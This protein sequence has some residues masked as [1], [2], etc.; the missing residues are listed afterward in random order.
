MKQTEFMPD[1]VENNYKLFY[2]KNIKFKPFFATL[3]HGILPHDKPVQK[4]KK[5]E[6]E[7]ISD[8]ENLWDIANEF[9]KDTN[10]RIVS[11]EEKAFKLITYISAISVLLV[12]FL[13]VG[14][15]G[16]FRWSV[17]IALFFLIIA[18]LISLRCIGLK[19]KMAIHV[20][21]MLNFDDDP[22]SFPT[23]KTK[24]EIVA[25]LINDS[26]YNHNVAD[27]T[28]DV[29]K[30]SR[31]MLTIG[32][33]ITLFSGI[34][35]INHLNTDV[36]MVPQQMIVTFKDSVM[37]RDIKMHISSTD[38]SLISLKKD[39]S[40]IQSKIVKNDSNKIIKR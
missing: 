34:L 29:L 37:V 1:V 25:K 36:K 10:N 39:I 21:T 16:A 18:I 26:V 20:D 14:A 23:V 9:Y 11:L 35:Y 2:P 31:Y 8:L 4:L 6:S 24:K 3:I 13:G 15:T 30:S 27:S 5:F 7:N 22:T 28:A 12:F 19:Q 38:S 32:I 40:K 33:V 17:I